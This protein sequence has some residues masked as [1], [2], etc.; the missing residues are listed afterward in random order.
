MMLAASAQY[1]PGTGT[2]RHVY[3]GK[4]FGDYRTVTASVRMNVCFNTSPFWP[5]IWNKA[6]CVCVC[7]WFVPERAQTTPVNQRPTTNDG[8]PS[9]VITLILMPAIMKVNCIDGGGY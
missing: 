5:A 9:G 7:A 2:Q 1:R 3:G 4:Y 6:G 8:L